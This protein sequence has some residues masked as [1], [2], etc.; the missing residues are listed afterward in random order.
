MKK[1]EKYKIKLDLLNPVSILD[2]GYSI[3]YK[4]NEI[5]KD[6]SLL[7]KDDD[8]NIIVKNGKINANVKG[9][10]KNGRKDIWK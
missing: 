3:V 1:T 9:V 2:K 8:I 5:I 6:V 4:G 7:S 10:E